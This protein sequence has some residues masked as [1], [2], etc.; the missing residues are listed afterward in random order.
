M[1]DMPKLNSEAIWFT[2]TVLNRFIKILSFFFGL[3]QLGSLEVRVV[4]LLLK[5]WDILY[6]T[7]S[8]K[9]CELYLAGA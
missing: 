4:T 9:I 8:S 5:V 7:G 1:L 2:N 6:P 3:D